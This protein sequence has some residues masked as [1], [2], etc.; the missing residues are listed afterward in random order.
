TISPASPPPSTSAQKL[1]ARVG[2][3][4]LILATLYLCYFSHLD[5]LGLIGPDEPRYAWIARDMMETGDYVTPRLYGK[6]WFE[7]PP[8]YYWGAALSFKLLGATEAAGRLPSAF[9]ALL[10]TLAIAWLA[11]RLYGA[12]TARWVLL[13]LPT[14]V[15]MIG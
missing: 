15:G 10:A 5:T 2:W 3:T 4:L 9:S 6:P 8:L 13:L 1:T 12:E 14:T 7:K 11:L